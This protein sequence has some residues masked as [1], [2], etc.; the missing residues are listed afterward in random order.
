MA[1]ARDLGSRLERGRGSSPLSRITTHKG[2][3]HD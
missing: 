2:I 1:D 3:L